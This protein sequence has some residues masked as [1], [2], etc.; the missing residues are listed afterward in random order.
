MG[1]AA[2]FD[3]E[4]NELFVRRMPTFFETFPILLTNK[5]GAV[6]ADIP[7]RRAESKYTIEQIGVSVKFF[8]GELDGLSCA[9]CFKIV[10]RF[11]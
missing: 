2:F 9:G 8:G 4:G 7:F 11:L 6:I 3:K 10:L 5:D 1:H